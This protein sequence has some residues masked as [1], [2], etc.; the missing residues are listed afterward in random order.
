M[1]PDLAWPVCN[2]LLFERLRP[3]HDP[4]RPLWPE[5]LVLLLSQSDIIS[6]THA[7]ALKVGTG[8][9]ALAA[10]PQHQDDAASLG[11]GRLRVMM[12]NSR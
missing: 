11:E 6:R 8:I 2:I 9:S 10:W 3:R 1:S 4:Y 7:V 12:K 5:T